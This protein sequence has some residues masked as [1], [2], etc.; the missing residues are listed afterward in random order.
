MTDV[1][2]IGGG[3]TGLALAYRLRARGKDAVLLEGEPRLG[4]SIQ[5]RQRDGLL[6]EAGPNGFLDKEPAMRD[7]AAGVGVE[8][9]NLIA[10][11]ARHQSLLVSRRGSEKEALEFIEHTADT[12]GWR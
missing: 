7:L 5:T 9:G 6:T 11:E 12:Q 8:E 1:A 10:Q 4:G 2:I 3:I